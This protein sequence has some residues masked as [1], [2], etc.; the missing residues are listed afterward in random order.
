M[1]IVLVLILLAYCLSDIQI[2]SPK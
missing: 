2:Y 1:K